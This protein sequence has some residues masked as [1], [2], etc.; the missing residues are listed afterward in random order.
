MQTKLNTKV[1]PAFKFLDNLGQWSQYCYI[2][3]L[4]TKGCKNYF[5]YA[6]QTGTRPVPVNKEGERKCGAWEF[7]HAGWDNSDKQKRQGATTRTLFPE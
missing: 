1:E 7:N 5:I 3:N 2:P 6:L 4:N